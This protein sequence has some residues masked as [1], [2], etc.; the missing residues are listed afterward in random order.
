MKL[1]GIEETQGG[2]ILH[3]PSGRPVPLALAS[4][5]AGAQTI[6]RHVLAALRSPSEPAATI[7]A[8]KRNSWPQ[9]AAGHLRDTAFEVLRP[10]ED[11]SL[12]AY[13]ERIQGATPSVLYQTLRKMAGR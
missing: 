11:E 5:Y 12:A 3:L 9:A 13:V 2:V 1:F 8:R 4:G 6:G 10:Y 7:G